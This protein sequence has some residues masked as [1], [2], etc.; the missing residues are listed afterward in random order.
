MCGHHGMDCGH[1]LDER[2]ACYTPRSGGHL[3]GCSFLIAHDESIDEPHDVERCVVDSDVGAQ[4]KGGSNRNG[5]VLECR[6]NS[7]LSTNVVCT[8]KCVAKW[9]SAQDKFGVVRVGN[10]KGEI[11][12]AA[13]DE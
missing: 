6:N 3:V 4:A 13:G 1:G 2:S 11:R 9:W 10:K 8:S 7:E 5:R 12:V